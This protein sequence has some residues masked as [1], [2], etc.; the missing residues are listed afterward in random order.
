M[1]CISIAIHTTSCLTLTPQVLSQ[2]FDAHRS[3]I[4]PE[5]LVGAQLMIAVHHGCHCPAT[6][7]LLMHLILLQ[8][9]ASVAAI[10]RPRIFPA[11][12]HGP[13]DVPVALLAHFNTVRL[14]ASN[15]LCALRNRCL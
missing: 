6:P 3:Y 8:L 5:Q 1:H 7:S 15:A 13:F 4:S 14:H 2:A 9:A 12:T 11:E 10:S